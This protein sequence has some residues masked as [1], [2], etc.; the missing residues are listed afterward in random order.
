MGAKDKWSRPSMVLLLIHL[1]PYK[2]RD[3]NKLKNEDKMGVF[4]RVF[5]THYFFL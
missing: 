3:K 2:K 5:K 4:P 1:K